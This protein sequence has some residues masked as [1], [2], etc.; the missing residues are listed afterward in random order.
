MKGQ[1]SI[2]ALP[3]ESQEKSVCTWHGREWTPG[4]NGG[5]DGDDALPLWTPT[6]LTLS[7]Y[8]EQ[9]GM[10]GQ[11]V[12]DD[13]RVLRWVG[14]IDALHLSWRRTKMFSNS[15]V[16]LE[17]SVTSPVGLFRAGF[18]ARTIFCFE[19]QKKPH[20]DT[21]VELGGGG[22]M[23]PTQPRLRSTIFSDGPDPCSHP[24]GT[25]GKLAC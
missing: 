2:I 6:L 13:H 20:L 16:W 5:L 15:F 10:V 8:L 23:E 11:E 22:F 3:T 25:G 7:L 21:W 14:H 24:R 19:G 1:I 12:L 9:V 17:A 18:E 4:V